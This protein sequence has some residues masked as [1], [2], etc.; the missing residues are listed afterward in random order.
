MTTTA[1]ERSRR[2]EDWGYAISAALGFLIPANYKPIPAASV[3]RALLAAVPSATGRV[4]LLSGAM[5]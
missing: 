2:G 4:V 3:A 1:L 5:R